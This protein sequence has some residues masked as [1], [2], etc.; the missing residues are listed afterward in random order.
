MVRNQDLLP[1]IPSGSEVSASVTSTADPQGV[2]ADHQRGSGDDVRRLDLVRHGGKVRQ[3]C[4]AAPVASGASSVHC[5][6]VYDLFERGAELITAH[7][8]D[9][10]EG[11]IIESLTAIAAPDG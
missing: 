10:S 1:R 11:A 5:M 4:A 9:E 8:G 2:Q 7:L 3:A 6:K